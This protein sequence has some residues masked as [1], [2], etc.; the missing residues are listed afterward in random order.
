MNE[1]NSR[2]SNSPN[3]AHCG[4]VN[5]GSAN[6]ASTNQINATTSLSFANILHRQP[7]MVE[8]GHEPFND[9]LDRDQTQPNRTKSTTK[10]PGTPYTKYDPTDDQSNHGS[11]QLDGFNRRRPFCAQCTNHGLKIDLKGHKRHCR[12]RSCNCAKCEITVE[13]RKI[14]AKQIAL[15]REMA[16]ESNRPITVDQPP[17]DLVQL[18]A[19]PAVQSNTI[20]SPAGGGRL[21]NNNYPF[22][23]DDNA[24]FLKSYLEI[25]FPRLDLLS[26]LIKA[27]LK[28]NN[29]DIN[30]TIL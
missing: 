20:T 1:S 22:S 30:K 7:P 15:R 13:R 19:P 10:F 9:G 24:I 4:S 5:H 25:V 16:E 18:S 12:Y 27:N 23:L 21:S 6:S 17:T 28:A 3:I 8:S 26:I 29:G 2:S 14:N 11:S